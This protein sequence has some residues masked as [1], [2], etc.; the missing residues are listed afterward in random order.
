MQTTQPDPII[1]EVHTFRDEYAA[2]FNYDVGR[3]FHDIRARQEASKREYVC[4]PA[5]RTVGRVGKSLKPQ[6]G[7]RE[8]ERFS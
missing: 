6:K 8:Q 4:Y 3:I 7:T 2:R 5:R 1:T